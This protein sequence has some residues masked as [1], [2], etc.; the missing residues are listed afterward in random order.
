MPETETVSKKEIMMFFTSPVN[1]LKAL[2]E[3]H[4]SY[5]GIFF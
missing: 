2:H 5:N 3:K 4:I 1:F